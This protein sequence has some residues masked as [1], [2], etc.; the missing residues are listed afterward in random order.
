V[1]RLLS[2]FDTVSGS[3]VQKQLTEK[4]ANIEQLRLQGRRAKAAHA[5]EIQ[6]LTLQLQQQRF[7]AKTL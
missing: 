1:I 6:D 7:Y 4:D 5:Q 3:A 2:P